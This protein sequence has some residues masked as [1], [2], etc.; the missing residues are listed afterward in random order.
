MSVP[1]FALDVDGVLA[2]F[3]GRLC[4]RMRERASWLPITPADVTTWDLR[5]CMTP[6]AY[7]VS[8]AVMHEPGFAYSLDVY[9]GAKELVDAC[10]ARGHVVALTAPLTGSPTWDQERRAWLVE[11]LGF[12]PRD[13]V[14]CPS[15]HKPRFAADVLVEDCPSTLTAWRE[16]HRD[17]WAFLVERPWTTQAAKLEHVT[18]SIKSYFPRVAP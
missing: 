18:E 8:D 3:V 9:E 10:R 12:S 6:Q 16:V 1:L 13:V 5:Q 17:S 2:D 11:R 7:E 15:Q 14:F 4:E